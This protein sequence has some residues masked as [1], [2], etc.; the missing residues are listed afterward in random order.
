MSI[1]KTDYLFL[2]E[3]II[4]QYMTLQVF[5]D[6]SFRHVKCQGNPRIIRLLDVAVMN[7]RGPTGSRSGFALADSLMPSLALMVLGG[8]NCL[9]RFLTGYTSH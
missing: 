3:V 6:D 2:F 4:V 7:P 8:A 1:L 5:L 9:E